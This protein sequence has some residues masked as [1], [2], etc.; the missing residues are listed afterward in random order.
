MSASAGVTEMGLETGDYISDL[1]STNPT[2]VDQKLQ[3]D[4]HL[5][6]IKHVLKTSF[7]NIDGAMTA[8]EEILNAY[9]AI[10]PL[11]DDYFIRCSGTAAF[12]LRSPAQVRSDIGADNAANL[13]SG[14][15]DDARLSA[16]VPLLNAANE[17]TQNITINHATTA[18]VTMS[19]TAVR[20]IAEED[21]HAADEGRWRLDVNTKVFTWETVSD[22]NATQRNIM[23]AT[24]GT[25]IALTRIAIG[26]T[27]DDAEVEVHCSDFIFTPSDNTEYQVGYRNIPQNSQAGNYT[28]VIGD[29]GKMIYKASGGAG[30]TITIPANASV[31]FPVGTV[32]TFANRGGGTLTIAIT[33]DTLVFAG[34]GSTGSRILA[35]AGLATA[36][37]VAS[38]VWMISGSGLT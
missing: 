36:V 23:S 34:V 15:L 9:A 29:A 13:T 31:A 8:T 37:K 4:D 2:G 7:P 25:G 20:I 11:T 12:E 22:D 18:A 30:E 6:L 1:V 17:F 3:G 38:T 19:G 14:D 21:G 10:F 16:N 27:T 32:V 35:D 5:R 24:R 28:L 33:S 26:N